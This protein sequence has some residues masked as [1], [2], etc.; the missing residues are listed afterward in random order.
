MVIWYND[1]KKYERTEAKCEWK[2][3]ARKGPSIWLLQ[4]PE[5]LNATQI[6]LIGVEDRF[7]FTS[8]GL[9]GCQQAPKWKV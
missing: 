7:N 4:P 1:I 5:A 9:S 2:H 8:N 3:S 6:T